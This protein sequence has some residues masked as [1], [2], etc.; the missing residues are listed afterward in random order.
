[1]RPTSSALTSDLTTATLTSPPPPAPAAG[2][3]AGP[4]PPVP[5]WAGTDPGVDIRPMMAAF[6]SGVAVITTAAPDGRPFGMT[7]SSLCSAS[8]APP[9]VLACLRRGSPTLAQIRRSGGFVL[10]FLQSHASPVAE[11]FASGRPDRFSLVR[12]APGPAGRGPHL[13]GDAHTIGDFAVTSTY[14]V[15]DHDVV[16]GQAVSVAV[17]TAPEPLLYG[18]RRFRTWTADAARRPGAPEENQ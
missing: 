14:P 15:G 9:M 8:L 16:I 11:L 7:C 10:N 18:L 12:W 17:L 13:T 3:A 6:P 4:V 5:P 2:T 1:M